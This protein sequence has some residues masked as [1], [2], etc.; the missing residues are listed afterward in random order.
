MCQ[1]TS[2]LLWF[3]PLNRSKNLVCY[4]T[5]LQPRFRDLIQIDIIYKHNLPN[6]HFLKSLSISL[7]ATIY[8][9]RSVLVF[10]DVLIYMQGMMLALHYDI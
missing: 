4:R 8:F 7:C 10:T 3:Q 2:Q 9:L 5:I 6:S 1:N